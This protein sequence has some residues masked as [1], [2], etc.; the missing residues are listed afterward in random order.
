[1]NIHTLYRPFLRHFRKSR[2]QRFFAMFNI[3]ATTRVLDLGGNL[4]FWKLAR[5]LGRPQPFVT[6]VNLYPASE[7]LPD[8]IEWIVA[9]GTELPF[10]EQSFDVVFC[11]SV[12]EHLGTWQAQKKFAEEI[13]RVS[14]RHFVQCPHKYFPVEPHLITPFVHWVPRRFRIRLLR[15]FTVWGWMTR[16]R[17]ED[18][19]KMIEELQ[20]L[21]NSEMRRLFPESQIQVERLLGLPKS[22]IA[23]KNL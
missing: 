11:N 2:L 13:Y 5:E 10:A 9:D 21:G 8:K 22:L 1:M 7:V 23:I 4:F 19:R 14:S 15:N 20:L 3:Q 17:H 6:I 16:P 12:I 18:C